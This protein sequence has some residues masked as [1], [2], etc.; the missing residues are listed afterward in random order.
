MGDP[1]IIRQI[2]QFPFWTTF[3]SYAVA[4]I[5]I[6]SVELFSGSQEQD[7]GIRVLKEYLYNLN[8]R[9][10]IAGL[11]PPLQFLKALI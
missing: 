2:L 8:E 9:W 10:R 4:M 3:I 7:N 6:T 1:K 5:L 11:C